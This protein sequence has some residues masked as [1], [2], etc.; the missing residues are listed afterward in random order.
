MFPA[1][2]GHTCVFLQCTHSA[3]TVHAQCTATV[4]GL[5]TL[6]IPQKMAPRLQN[7]EKTGCRIFFWFHAISTD[8]VLFTPFPA[9][10]LRRA[11]C[12]HCQNTRTRPAPPSC[13]EPWCC[14]VLA[15]AVCLLVSLCAR[16]W[17]T[18]VSLKGPCSISR[19]LQIFWEYV[20]K[21]LVFLFSGL[22]AQSHGTPA[23]YACLHVSLYVCMYV[24]MYVRTCWNIDLR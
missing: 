23:A 18:I 2:A 21:S 10:A 20:C 17:N 22:A 6:Q 24:C 7:I 4:H 15:A 11:L 5:E 12:V 9:R 14:A 19:Y 3:R 1:S 13:S 16:S 8:D